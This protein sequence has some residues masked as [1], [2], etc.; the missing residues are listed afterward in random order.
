MGWLRLGLQRGL[1]SA[2]R[3][4]HDAFFSLE[5]EREEPQS[6]KEEIQPHQLLV[7]GAKRDSGFVSHV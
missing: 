4:P 1:C 6:E 7:R 5:E 2:L 3:V